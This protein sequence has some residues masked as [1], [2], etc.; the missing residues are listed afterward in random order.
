M[1]PFATAGASLQLG[2]FQRP[3]LDFTRL[4]AKLDL[5][6]PAHTAEG[7][8]GA[9]VQGLEGA[10]AVLRLALH[11]RVS[12]LY[13]CLGCWPTGRGA[14]EAREARGLRVQR[15]HCNCRSHRRV[16]KLYVYLGCRPT[17]QEAQEVR[18]QG[19]GACKR[20]QA[21]YAIGVP[22]GRLY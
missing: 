9:R 18:F 20:L 16:S 7:A 4:I 5:G 12:K 1:R 22:C 13:V 19:A 17:E 8:G 10:E 2:W 11:R 3:V 6:L 15:W 21:L 14:Q